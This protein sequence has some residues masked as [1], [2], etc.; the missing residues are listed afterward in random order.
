M[1]DQV[2]RE[3]GTLKRTLSRFESNQTQWWSGFVFAGCAGFEGA[4]CVSPVE[5]QM[6]PLLLQL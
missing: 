4:F 2:D 5:R 1:E 3:D 6:Y